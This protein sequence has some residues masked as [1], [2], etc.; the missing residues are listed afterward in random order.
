MAMYNQQL[1]GPTFEISPVIIPP[2][3]HSGS[4]ITLDNVHV[5]LNVAFTKRVID[6]CQK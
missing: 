1:V 5:I 3:Q 6:R 4:V 2:C